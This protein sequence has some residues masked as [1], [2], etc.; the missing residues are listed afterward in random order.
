MS[1][2][3]EQYLII[4]E[5]HPDLMLMCKIGGFYEFLLQDAHE[6]ASLL[7]LNLITKGSY[8]DAPVPMC[9][10]PSKMLDYTIARL[11]E[12]N[13]R[14]GIIEEMENDD[15]PDRRKI[16]Q[17]QLAR[18]ITPGTL[19]DS[20]FLL[21]SDSNPLLGIH[22]NANHN[23]NIWQID[24]STGRCFYEELHSSALENHLLQIKPREI[25][26]I[27][28]H[29]EIKDCIDQFS[30]I[31]QKALL[32][33]LSIC[34][35]RA[36]G[37]HTSYSHLEAIPINCDRSLLGAI[38]QYIYSINH[39]IPPLRF[40][41]KPK[42]MLLRMNYATLKNLD[43][44]QSCNDG[45]S[46]LSFLNLTSTP[47]G[48]R[49]IKDELR[50]PSND[51]IAIENRVE[52]VQLLIDNTTIAQSLHKLFKNI[53]D[54][55]RIALRIQNHKATADDLVRLTSS[56]AAIYQIIKLLHTN[57]TQSA[58][59]SNVIA[60][61]GMV[62]S[63]NRQLSMMIN[64]H[65]NDTSIIIKG[66]DAS[67]DSIKE[68]YHE[69]HRSINNLTLRYR[70]ESGAKIDIIQKIGYGYVIAVRN[71]EARSI[72]TT[73]H[74]TKPGATKTSF[75]TEELTLLTNEYQITNE[76]FLALEAAAIEKVSLEIIPHISDILSLADNIAELD[77]LLGFSILARQ[78]NY[79]RPQFTDASYIKI[80]QGKHPILSSLT[81]A[82]TFVANDLCLNAEQ[83]L[84]IIFGTNMSGKSTFLR[85]NALI[86]IMAHM[87]SFVPCYSAT[88]PILDNIF[89]RIGSGDDAYKAKSTFYLEMEEIAEMLHCAN[90][91]SLCLIDEIGRGTTH[92]EG[93]AVAKA[94]IDYLVDTKSFAILATHHHTLAQ[95]SAT[96]NAVTNLSIADPIITDGMPAFSY[97]I[98]P[99]FHVYSNTIIATAKLANMPE[100]VITLIENYMLSSSLDK[101]SL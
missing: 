46:L 99:G 70:K 50:Q 51:R 6:A 68:A 3:V 53:K 28:D 1:M 14:I 23:L 97:K 11:L 8:Q 76:R 61:H 81:R 13:K 24:V 80:S 22:I 19:Q 39:V 85:Q 69:L 49:R 56:I 32:P 73:W 17:R 2:I 45:C 40:M 94:V 33:Y 5:A 89:C 18:I 58:I 36:L 95:I 86:C 43:I 59:T 16:L 15:Y 63:L 93:I 66:F 27:S 26:I 38:L 35:P 88:I 82:N 84:N 34:I 87:G 74:I 77:I 52:T 67:L 48:S 100:K 25:V 41:A 55:E 7:Q 29:L 47:L 96:N 20:C 4:K 37:D 9:G 21:S 101:A 31:L 60:R 71:S 57:I 91:K 79:I 42:N 98:S 54:I 90:N 62:Q 83:R 44:L 10:V 78:Y 75:T 65:S 30:I 92:H 64:C 72:P 12:H